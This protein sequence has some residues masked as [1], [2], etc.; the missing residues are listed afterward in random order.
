MT[1]S[2]P[3]ILTQVA[4]LALVGL[5]MFSAG[6]SDWLEDEIK[7]AVEEEVPD[8]STSNSALERFV[9]YAAI[10][11]EET[12]D[13]AVS[14]TLS[15]YTSTGEGNRA[16]L[17]LSEFTTSVGTTSLEGCVDRTGA[18]VY[19]LSGRIENTGIPL[20]YSLGDGGLGETLVLQNIA[21]NTG[22]TRVVG[23]AHFKYGPWEGQ[24]NLTGLTIPN[25]QGPSDFGT[26][27]LNGRV[28]GF[29]TNETSS[30]VAN[31]AFCF[32][33]T[34]SICVRIAEEGR[35]PYTVAVSL[36]SPR[37]NRSSCGCF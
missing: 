13:L 26:T 18:D 36:Q 27:Y 24:V 33:G 23:T 15:R 28:E 14:D 16:C 22:N 21:V 29:L 5:V 25:I 37:V 12:V 1:L 17:A 3:Q 32:N 9:S 30:K 7:S 8:S 20:A 2:R 19:E 11:F 10:L 6:C 31:I 4:M 35:E 34:S